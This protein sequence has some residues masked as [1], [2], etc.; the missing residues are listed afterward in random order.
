MSGEGIPMAAA[1]LPKDEKKSGKKEKNKPKTNPSAFDI[2]NEDKA[3]MME[4]E[5]ADKVSRLSN[6]PVGDSP[7][8]SSIFEGWVGDFSD[9]FRR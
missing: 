6:Y 4:I 7:H 9:V 2:S 8:R 1:G 3:R 5:H